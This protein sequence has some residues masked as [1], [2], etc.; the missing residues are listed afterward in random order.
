MLFP[1]EIIDVITDCVAWADKLT[2][3]DLSSGVIVTENDYT[4]NFTAALRR[5]VTARSIPGLKA[6]IQV[7]SPSVERGNGVDGCIILS[8][9]REFKVGMFEAKWPRLS[10]KIN[11]W[12]SL[13]RSTGRSHFD[14]QIARQK[15]AAEHGVAV[16]EMFYSEHSF[17]E[18]PS[19]MQSEGSSCVWHKFASE[20]SL[21][22][23]GANRP[24]TDGELEALLRSNSTDT[25]SIIR[26][27]CECKQG[28]PRPERGYADALG[29]LGAP[30][31]ALVLSFPERS[32]KVRRL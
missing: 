23:A 29:N 18:Q 12:D 16:W 11:S 10:S 32:R 4:S 14:D 31:K 9:S 15:F 27:I 26:E 3:A 8:N 7:L 24:W 13:Q 17:G 22:R 20:A 19:F 28:T 30:E 21:M 5:E 25:A 1:A 2:R 6:R